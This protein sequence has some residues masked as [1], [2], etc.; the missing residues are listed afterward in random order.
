[1]CVSVRANVDPQVHTLKRRE[2]E[3]TLVSPR[4]GEGN[5]AL[6]GRRGF[7]QCLLASSQHA[8]PLWGPP[9]GSHL[10]KQDFDLHRLT[11]ACLP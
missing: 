9:D 3:K 1:M 5:Q 4:G 7:S 2:K 6:G 10:E 11:L 8:L